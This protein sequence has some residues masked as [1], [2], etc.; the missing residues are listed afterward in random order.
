[1]KNISALFSLSISL[2]VVLVG[3]A[4]A[5]VPNKMIMPVNG[6]GW[7]NSPGSPAHSVSGGIGGADDTNALDL[8]LANDADNGSPVY[9]MADG[10]VERNLGGGGWGG[11]TYGQLL[12]KHQNPDGS[13]YYCGY[14]HMSSITA[15]KATQGAY[16]PAGTVIGRVSNTYP[17]TGLANHLHVACY[18]WDGTKL[19][20][21]PIPVDSVLAQVSSRPSAEIT[22]SIQINGTVVNTSPFPVS[23]TTQFQMFLTLKNTGAVVRASNYYAILTRDYNGSEYVGQ[24]GN[25]NYCLNLNPGGTSSQWIMK[26][27]GF[28]SPPGTYFLQIYYDDCSYPNAALKRVSGAPLSI[29][30]Y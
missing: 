3:N 26:N 16:I 17:T 13:A 7:Y 20:S 12:L 10:W 27:S 19:R 29:R 9:A 28:S 23:R 8:N 6:T 18:T 21:K 30:L 11:S 2:A 22:G 5:Q 25:L 14:L 1:M 4:S 15:L 24:V